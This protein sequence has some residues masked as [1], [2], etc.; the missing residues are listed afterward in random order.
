MKKFL[1]GLICSHEDAN[2]I[3]HTC[4]LAL[5][6]D[7]VGVDSD[8]NIYEEHEMEEPRIGIVCQ[9]GTLYITNL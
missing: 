2:G 9:Y 1:K 6:S 8:G 3:C 4:Y 5:G 7:Y